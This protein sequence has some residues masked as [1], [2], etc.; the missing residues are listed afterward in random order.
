VSEDRRE[1]KEQKVRGRRE[2]LNDNGKKKVLHEQKD[3][4]EIEDDINNK[5][6][7][8]R[9]G[10]NPV[11]GEIAKH[12][13]AHSITPSGGLSILRWPPVLRLED[14][15]CT[16][17][18]RKRNRC[19]SKGKRSAKRETGADM[20][21]VRRLSLKSAKSSRIVPNR[22][23]PMA[24]WNVTRWSDGLHFEQLAPQPWARSRRDKQIQTWEA[25][26]PA[27]HP[28]S[29]NMSRH[30]CLNEQATGHTESQL[31]YKHALLQFKV[32]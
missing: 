32:K 24:V 4:E 20:K 8:Q 2:D 9:W 5:L 22:H 3:D 14:C 26:I 30:A 28:T 19:D 27:K 21:L 18:G 15:L 16:N 23:V 25:S 29:R 10:G 17:V 6:D 11:L 13:P 1:K 12:H 7:P 31:A